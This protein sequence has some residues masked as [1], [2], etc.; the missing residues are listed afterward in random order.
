MTVYCFSDLEGGSVWE[1]AYP[2]GK[3][4]ES[5]T[6]AGVKLFRDIKAEHSGQRSGDAWTDYTSITRGV[7]LPQM[8]AAQKLDAE[9][10]VPTDY[11][12]RGPMALPR[13]RNAEHNRK[14]NRA[15]KW[16]SWDG[17]YKDP[18]PGDFVKQ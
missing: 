7:P 13:M 1:R 3:A 6:I 2:M 12:V 14:W 11:E 8:K 18:V 16:G 5:I 15:H 17:G 4:P 9:L 10:G